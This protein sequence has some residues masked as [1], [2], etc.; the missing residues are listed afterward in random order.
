MGDAGVF[1][2]LATSVPVPALL[3]VDQDQIQ[4]LLKHM[5]PVVTETSSTSKVMSSTGRFPIGQ[6]SSG[7]VANNRLRRDEMGSILEGR[8]PNH[9]LGPLE[10]SMCSDP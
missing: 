4:L 5:S 3:Y 9:G 8:P 2:D 1:G 6:L 10:D 7:L